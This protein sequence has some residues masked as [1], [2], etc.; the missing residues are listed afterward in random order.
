VLL[1]CGL[2]NRGAGYKYTRHNIGYLVIDRFAERLSIPVIKKASKCI[3]GEGEGL[4][5]AKPDTYMNLSGG[6]LASLMKRRSIKPAD[7]VLIHDDLDMEFGR[8]RIRWNGSDGGHKG[9]RSVIESLGSALFHRLKIGMG[10]D[11]VLPPEEFVLT[12]FKVDEL[13]P[14]SDVL[15]TAVDALHTF[16]TD[17][18]AKAMSLFNRS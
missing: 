5:L 13:G 10:R 7:L 18:P 4:V 11:P 2:G 6:P 16:V 9:V 1:V 12:R 3:I 14:L 15:D 17:G 8:T